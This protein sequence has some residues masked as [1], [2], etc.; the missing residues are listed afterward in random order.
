MASGPAP[1]SLQTPSDSGSS[2]ASESSH[3]I[4]IER[5]GRGRDLGTRWAIAAG[6][7]AVLLALAWVA[8][9]GGP[10]E[11]PAPA[12]TPVAVQR[13]EAPPLE[14]PEA[15]DPPPAEVEVERAPV[16]PVA[17]VPVEAAPA[18]PPARSVITVNAV[19]WGEVRVD[20]R[21]VGTTPQRRISLSA[22]THAVEVRCPPLGRVART[23]VEVAAGRS[24]TLIA[25]LSQDPATIRVR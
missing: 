24:L 3:E 6:A 5:R 21:L 17:I 8:V 16:E 19:P 25:D 20:G 7:G 1:S 15:P 9:N 23:D 13:L 2:M 22:G 14:V 11:A 10:V 12:E 18:P 4:S